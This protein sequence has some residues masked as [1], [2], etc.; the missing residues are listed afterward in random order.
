MLDLKITIKGILLTII[1][2]LTIAFSL[3]IFQNYSS[4]NYSQKNKVPEIFGA[5]YMNLNND[6]FYNLNEEIVQQIEAKEDE[7]ISLD[8]SSSLDKQISQMRYLMNQGCKVIFLSPVNLTGLNSIIEECIEKDIVIIVIDSSI[9]SDLVKYSVVSDNYQAGT[10]IGEEIM[11]TMDSSNIL[12][13]EHASAQSAI[14]RVSGF[15]NTI[16]KDEN[17][18]VVDTLETEGKLEKTMLLVEDYIATG[19]DF[20][21][22]MA[23]NDEVAIGA[24]AALDKANIKDVKVYAVDGSPEAKQLMQNGLMDGSVAQYTSLLALESVELAYKALDNINLNETHIS[25]SVTL[26]TPE[27]VN[28]FDVE[29]WQ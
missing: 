26:I 10:L 3:T 18:Q 25:V 9:T 7:L 20:D 24:L 6:Y 5:T 2:L 17:Y 15:L 8:A 11:E 1:S 23:L 19:T 14:D 13:L 29:G 16:N 22:I 27:N 21:V 28:D 12:V 4:L